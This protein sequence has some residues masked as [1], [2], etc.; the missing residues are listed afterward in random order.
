MSPIQDPRF[1][2]AHTDAREADFADSRRIVRWEYLK[3]L[4]T[5]VIALGAT[6]LLGIVGSQSPQ[7][8]LVWLAV[9][10]GGGLVVAFIAL[11]IA[12][13]L[14]LGDAGP[15]GLAALRLAGALVGAQMVWA[16]FGAVPLYGIV[17][18]SF[19]Y[20]VLIVWLFEFDLVDAVL[21]AVLSWM[22]VIAVIVGLIVYVQS[23]FL[24]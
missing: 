17:L 15:K 3:A 9:K 14:F 12:E 5:L 20:A 22:L 8:A 13:Q 16:V 7:I 23:A 1:T 19:A 2:Q 21:L 10:L 24:S 4:L 18:S 11:L 6:L